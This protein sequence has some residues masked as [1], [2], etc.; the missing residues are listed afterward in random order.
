MVT[1]DEFKDALKNFPAGVTIVTSLDEAGE[2]V[3]ATVSAFA[4]VSVDPPLILV[5]LNSHSRTAAAARLTRAFN[6][7]FLDSDQQE[8]ARRFAFDQSDKFEKTDYI[9]GVNGAPLI[10]EAATKLQCEFFAE[11]QAGTHVVMI[12]A[13]IAAETRDFDPLVYAKRD[14]WSLQSLSLLGL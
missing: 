10:C 13:V 4:S 9:S 1:S 5:C 6:V 2:P 12:G 3:G 14:F 11:M 8:L 7:H